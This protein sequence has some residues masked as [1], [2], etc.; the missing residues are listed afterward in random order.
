MELVIHN[1]FNGTD[2]PVTVELNARVAALFDALEDFTP[3]RISLVFSGTQLESSKTLLSY[4]IEPGSVI[5][6][7][8]SKKGLAIQQLADMRSKNLDPH[9]TAEGIGLLITA[10]ELNNKATYQLKVGEYLSDNNLCL[11]EAL[12]TNG[13]MSLV[14]LSDVLKSHKLDFIKIFEKVG[15]T[16]I[17][18][19]TQSLTSVLGKTN[20]SIKLC[21]QIIKYLVGKVGVD[22]KDEPDVIS[23]AVHV[24][25][26]YPSEQLEIIS[27]LC[28]RG[29]VP[30]ENSLSSA[31]IQDGNIALV[32][33]LADR[34]VSISTLTWKRAIRASQG[35]AAS[36]ICSR[37]NFELALD[38]SDTDILWE[39]SR[40]GMPATVLDLLMK[41]FSPTCTFSNKRTLLMVASEYGSVET[42]KSLIQHG[43]DVHAV[44]THF[45]WNA[46][47]YAYL[48]GN[49]EIMK[50]LDSN[51]PTLKDHR[52]VHGH[53]ASAYLFD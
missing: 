5:D 16:E 35:E 9:V 7:T 43:V 20:P 4:G 31:V 22:V 12:I 46:L 8:I 28:E 13:D 42:V 6:L 32:R 38:D 36:Y 11:F 45:Q 17:F 41:R 23:K 50:E 29:A 33:Y 34:V 27:Y 2:T 53:A 44:D 1:E 37:D 51:Y 49:R 47:F 30:C 15:K 14:P 26:N 39:A 3:D 25:K 24:F 40:N 48:G 19:G 21:E 52:D 18:K 10:G